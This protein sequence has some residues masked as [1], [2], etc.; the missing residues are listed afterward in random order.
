VP[1]RNEPAAGRQRQKRVFAALYRQSEGHAVGCFEN[2][3]PL[4]LD[5]ACFEEPEPRWTEHG[6]ACLRPE[7]SDQSAPVIGILLERERSTCKPDGGPHGRGQRTDTESKGDTVGVP[8]DE[9]TN[10]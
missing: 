8:R 4:R 2:N 1:F 9:K 3:R 5:E 6:D 10:G 7:P